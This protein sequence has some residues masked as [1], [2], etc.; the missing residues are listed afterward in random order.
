MNFS[1]LALKYNR[2]QVKKTT[3][4]LKRA[5]RAGKTGRWTSKKNRI[6]KKETPL[7]LFTGGGFLLTEQALDQRTK[8]LPSLPA[9]PPLT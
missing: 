3:S 7:R 5:Q 9:L 6:G 2:K 1:R 4:I 8:N